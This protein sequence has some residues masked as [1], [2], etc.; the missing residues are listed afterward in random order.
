MSEEEACKFVVDFVY[1]RSRI[2]LHDGKEALIRSRLS[3]RMRERG[4]ETL[5]QYCEFLQTKAT[6][7]ELTHVMDALTTNFTNF[8]REEAHFKFML[9]VAL[10]SMLLPRQKQFNIWSAASSSGEEAYSMAF[11]LMEKYPEHAGW[12]WHITGSDISTRVLE[13]ARQAVYPMERVQTI[14]EPWLK[15]YL[16]KGTGKWEG[17][18]R[19]RPELTNRVNFRQVNLIENYEHTQKF[20]IIFCRNVMIY[21]NRETQEQLVGQ[22]CKHLVPGGYLLIGHSESLHGLNLPLNCLKPSIY[23]LITS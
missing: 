21:F 6:A 7:D 12:D 20:Q 10:P 17:Y 5:A 23:Q 9:D 16:Q 2:R 15:K 22:L 4:C 1:D 3:K 19:V 11:Y 14:P 13:T 8:L 18:C